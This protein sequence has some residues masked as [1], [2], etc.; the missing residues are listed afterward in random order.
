MRARAPGVIVLFRFN[1]IIAKLVFASL[2][3]SILVATSLGRVRTGPTI[4]LVPA[5]FHPSGHGLDAWNQLTRDARSVKIQAILNPANGPGERRDSSYV[6]AV[7][8]LR[9]A[10]GTV[11][12]YVFTGYG[13]RDITMVVADIDKY[14]RY[15]NI[16]GIFVDEMASTGEK[17]PYYQELYRIIKERN[18]DFQ[19]TGNPGMPFTLESYLETADTLVIFEGSSSTHADF[20]P[21]AAAPWVANHSAHRFAQ[22]IYGVESEAELHRVLVRA[23]QRNAGSVYVTDG[24]LP[25]PYAGLPHYWLKEVDAVRATYRTA[26]SRAMS[27]STDGV[28]SGDDSEILAVSLRRQYGPAGRTLVQ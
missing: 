3:A 26:S 7:N 18:P 10:G 8:R 20:K 9:S 2:V 13:K 4:A 12:G 1:G 28:S 5:Y 16:N 24:R 11:L 14:E 25:N 15:Y 19:V 27:V 22:I 21:L 17:L 6:S 23:G